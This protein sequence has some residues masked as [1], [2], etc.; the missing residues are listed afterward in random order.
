MSVKNYVIGIAIL[1]LTIA[2]V[3]NGVNLFYGDNPDYNDYCSNVRYPVAKP[4][5]NES[6]CPAVCVELYEIQGG[7]CVFNECGSGCGADGVVGFE[8][9]KQCEI[10][11]S[12]ETCYDA[13]D[14][15][16]EDYAKNLFFITL[17]LGILVIVIGA[18]VFGLESVGAGLMAGGVGVILWGIVSFWSFAD[19]WIKFV[20][21]LIGLVA[22]IYLAYYFNERLGRKK[23]K[24]SKR[25]K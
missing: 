15:A 4:L 21:S 13:Y 24:K 7:E 25:E 19:N 17:I 18:L 16:R 12:G 2:V 8:T 3:I 6:V 11:L 10:V 22:L 1:I 14:D 5:N 20:L 23:G 9:Q